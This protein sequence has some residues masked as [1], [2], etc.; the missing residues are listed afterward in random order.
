MAIFF[1]SPIYLASILKYSA[2]LRAAEA[3]LLL[4]VSGDLTWPPSSRASISPNTRTWHVTEREP[5]QSHK[6]CCSGFL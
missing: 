5:S 6:C 1:N 3:F 2:V 4:I